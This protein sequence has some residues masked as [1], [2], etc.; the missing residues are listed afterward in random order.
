MYYTFQS[1]ELHKQMH[2][3]VSIDTLNLADK[4]LNEDMS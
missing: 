2:H 4:C 1:I 3:N